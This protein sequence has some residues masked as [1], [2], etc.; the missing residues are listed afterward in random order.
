MGAAKIEAL[1]KWINETI[2]EVREANANFFGKGLTGMC[3]LTLGF[4][5]MGG[6]F[7]LY[8]EIDLTS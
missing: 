6:E 4:T 2:S 5:S 3:N 1:A 7:N 8:C